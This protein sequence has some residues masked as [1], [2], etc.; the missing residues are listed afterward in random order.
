MEALKQDPQFWNLICGVL[1][2]DKYFIQSAGINAYV[3]RTLTLEVFYKAATRKGLDEHVKAVFN[4]IHSKSFLLEWSKHVHSSSPKS[5]FQ[6]Q[7]LSSISDDVKDT[8]A[9]LTAWRDFLLI[10]AVYKPLQLS[11]DAKEQILAN[12]LE[13]FSKEIAKNNSRSLILLSELFLMLGSHWKSEFVKLVNSEDN[14]SIFNILNEVAQEVN[15]VHPREQLVVVSIAVFT[16]RMLSNSN[17]KLSKIKDWIVPCCQ[18]LKKAS[19]LVHQPLDPKAISGVLKLPIVIICLLNELIQESTGSLPVLKSCS[20]FPV[21]VSLLIKSLKLDDGMDLSHSI[22]TLFLT[23]ASEKQAAE[24]LC[25]S[26]FMPE[27]T[28]MLSETNL[29]NPILERK[30]KL[31]SSKKKVSKQDVYFAHLRFITA[32]LQTLGNY[33]LQDCWNFT[34]VHQEILH[35]SLIGTRS[36]LSLENIQ[37]AILTASFIH[38][39]SFHQQMWKLEQPKSLQILLMDI[40]NCIYSTVAILSKPGLLKYLVMH[41]MPPDSKLSPT[42]SIDA[43]IVLRRGSSESES[44]SSGDVLEVEQKLFELLCITL[45]VLKKYTPDIAETMSGFTIDYGQWQLFL[46]VNFSIPSV[47]QVG[48]ISFGTILA[49]V[50]MCLKVLAKNEK[51][52][53]PRKNTESSSPINRSLL[54]YILEVSL[55][56]LL[57]QSKVAFSHPELPLREKQLIKRELSA[58]LNSMNITI[59]R[60]LR[61]G[62]LSPAAGQSST[63]PVFSRSQ[64]TEFSFLKMISNLVEK[65]FK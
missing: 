44:E 42:K 20:V 65:L 63:S 3:I 62:P 54:M 36:S 13:H 31:V 39:L 35:E 4:D 61:R 23:M 46:T 56:I 22:F 59:N 15:V 43:E 49:C 14:N 48:P 34:G 10:V 38:Q 64:S 12:I 7:V 27:V 1:F 11:S 37:H 16:L 17:I 28:L 6:V 30:T 21:L 26:G 24:T 47:D 2:T 58:E 29:T 45:T 52:P 51:T 40:C 53:S 41:K 55:T 32:L 18:L 19:V 25:C 33:F 9:L 8:F 60:F 50:N 5:D 57:S